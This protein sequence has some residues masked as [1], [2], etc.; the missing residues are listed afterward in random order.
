MICNSCKQEKGDRFRKGVGSKVCKDCDKINRHKHRET[1]RAAAIRWHSKNPL[2]SW[3]NQTIK[4]HRKKGF[5][6]QFT[7]LELVEVAK[8]SA[9]CHYCEIELRWDRNVPGQKPAHNVPTLERINN[10]QHLDLDNIAIICLRCN[11]TKGP[12]TMS[13]FVTYCQR[14]AARFGHVK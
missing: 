4:N 13:E 1:L 8:S 14:I 9:H 6:V 12:R 3:A 10:E 11:T 2:R 5:D 7:N